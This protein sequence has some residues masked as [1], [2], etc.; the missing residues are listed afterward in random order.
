MQIAIDGPSGAGKST[1]SREVSKRLGFTYID[2]GALYRVIGLDYLTRGELKLDAISI[3]IAY[4]GGEQRV[5][6]NGR[7]VSLE[8]RDNSVSKAAS[9]L[10]ALPEVREFLL[11]TQRSHA[12]G[13]NVIVDGRDIGTTVLPDAELKIYLTAT[14]ED[15]ARRRYEEL[16]TRGAEVRYEEILK[17]VI[18]RDENDMTRAASPLRKA[19]DAIL[20]DTTGNSFEESVRQI[21]ALIK[22]RLFI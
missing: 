21:E 7:E 9:D 10:S 1:I 12:R 22:E 5:F 14:P 2:T 8:I 4:T 13:K 16:I 20:L 11:E 19:P 6:L 17:D 3:D 18:S 15:R